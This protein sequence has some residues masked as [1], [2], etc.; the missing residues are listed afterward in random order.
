MRNGRKIFYLL[1]LFPLLVFAQKYEIKAVGQLGVVSSKLIEFKGDIELTD[2][3]VVLNV[4][5]PSGTNRGEYNIVSRRNGAIY[6]T[7]GFKDYQVLLWEDPIDFKVMSMSSGKLKT[8]KG[9]TNTS[10]RFVLK[11]MSSDLQNQVMYYI[12][13]LE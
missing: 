4:N 1:L 9:K 11:D 3:L 7:D 10:H 6:A 2:S 5:T 13:Q 8:L 12:V